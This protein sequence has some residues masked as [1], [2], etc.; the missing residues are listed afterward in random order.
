MLNVAHDGR[1]WMLNVSVSPLGSR[2]VGVNVYAVPERTD[3]AGEPLIT[4]APLVEPDVR[5]V[6]VNAG[7][8][9]VVRPSLTRMMMFENVPTLEL[10][11]VPES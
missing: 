11:G 6:S 5:T 2:A 7:K 4:G 3:V 9:A 1:F 10:A 8:E